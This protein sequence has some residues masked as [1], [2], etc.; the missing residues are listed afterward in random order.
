MSQRQINIANAIKNYDLNAF[1]KEVQD[2]KA[3]LAIK[4]FAIATLQFCDYST[5]DVMSRAVNMLEQKE[6]DDTYM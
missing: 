3:E 6:D 5:R 1:L 2:L 4:D